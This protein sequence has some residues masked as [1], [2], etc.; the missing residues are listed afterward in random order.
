MSW[1]YCSGCSQDLLDDIQIATMDVDYSWPFILSC[2]NS[3]LMVFDLQLFLHRAISQKE[4]SC[5]ELKKS[6]NS[7]QCF[8]FIL[9]SECGE[10]V[11]VGA[12][13]VNKLYS[14]WFSAV[15]ETC[16]DIIVCF[17]VSS[18]IRKLILLIEV[19]FVRSYQCNKSTRP[20]SVYICFLSSIKVAG[21]E[22]NRAKPSPGPTCTSY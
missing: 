17:T 20:R 2:S 1:Y 22:H 10:V 4:K 3:V 16:R 21:T 9:S 15:I 6:W 7:W 13:A 5:L 8:L 12:I 19:E 14:S 11:E 18:N